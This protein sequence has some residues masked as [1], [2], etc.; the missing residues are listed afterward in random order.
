MPSALQ[1]G[2]SSVRDVVE[3]VYRLDGEERGDEYD[4]SC[5]NPEHDDRRPS[6][7]VNLVTGYWSCFSCG[8]GGDLARLGQVVLRK[9]LPAVE[10]LLKPST[11]EGVLGAVQR[12]L[13]DA[14]AHATARPRRARLHLP[15]R[16]EPGPLAYMR[17]RGFTND[18]SR[19]WGVQ[20]VP[21]D[22]LPGNRGEFTIR[23]SIAIPIRDQYGHLRAWCYRATDDSPK[24]QP[25]YLY[26]PEVEISELWFGLQHHYRLRHVA[27]VEGALDAMWCWQCGVPALALLGSKMGDRK[28]LELQRYRSVTLMAD[29][30]E[31]GELWVRRVTNLI[32]HRMPVYIG[33]YRSWMLSKVP[34]KDGTY[35]RATDPEKLRPIDLE[36]MHAMAVPYTNWRRA[37]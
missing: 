31:A 36:L 23:Q 9:P 11:P 20:W 2:V 17:G 4:I 27:I 25:K 5:P 21:E 19:Y 22:T 6:C 12:R 16:Y 26:T 14:T 7:S 13:R 30:D 34:E 28:I 35:K 1:Y 3:N 29:L 10:R 33:Q 24:W 32:G 18:T 8:I 37:S 15:D